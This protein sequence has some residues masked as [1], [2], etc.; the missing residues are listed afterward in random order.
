LDEDHG[1]LAR[2]AEGCCQRIAMWA[3]AGHMVFPDSSGLLEGEVDADDFDDEMRML[4]RL[5]PV[6]DH[7]RY[8]AKPRYQF[9]DADAACVDLVVTVGGAE[10]EARAAAAAPSAA[11]VVDLW[12][13]AQFAERT[14]IDGTGVAKILKRSLAQEVVAPVL[15]EVMAAGGEGYTF[16]DMRGSDGGDGSGASDTQLG[17][18]AAA[19][20]E[21]VGFEA[22][23]ERERQRG[24]NMLR[25]RLVIGVV[26]LVTFLMATAPLEEVERYRRK[27]STWATGGG[28]GVGLEGL[29]DMD[30]GVEEGEEKEQEEGGGNDCT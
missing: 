7:T 24:L 4:T 29:D 6:C 18:G 17:E 22:R 14:E 15:A 19:E 8:A 11:A 30:E 21:E 13:F 9:T 23:E 20:E 10:V 1:V 3:G 27:D 5:A 2:G 16:R 28:G 25:A 26:G 12:E